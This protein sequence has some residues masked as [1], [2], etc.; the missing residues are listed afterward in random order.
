MC[1]TVS[2][3]PQ[4]G[5][6]SIDTKARMG[7]PWHTCR[8]WHASSFL[9][10][11]SEATETSQ[12]KS[13]SSLTLTNIWPLYYYYGWTSEGVKIFFFFCSQIKTTTT[14]LSGENITSEDVKTFFF[15]SSPIFSE[16]TRTVG[17]HAEKFGR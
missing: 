14:T 1:S 5:P 6:C 16:K 7:N 11:A 3:S 12:W 9:W 15:C 17:W 2:V 10:H 8:T 4:M 13:S